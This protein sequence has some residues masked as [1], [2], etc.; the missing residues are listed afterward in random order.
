MASLCAAMFLLPYTGMLLSGGSYYASAASVPAPDADKI[1]TNEAELRAAVDDNAY[2][3]RKCIIMLADDISMTNNALSI[4]SNKDI[5][6]I[7]GHDPESR[8]PYKLIGAEGT[9]TIA[10]KGTLYL[11]GIIVT[12]PA[13]EKGSGVLIES[14]GS[15][16]LL[17]GEVSGNTVTGN[18]GGVYTDGHYFSMEGG[19]ISGNTATGNGGGIYISNRTASGNHDAVVISDDAVISGNSADGNGGGIGVETR[20]EL[21]KLSVHSGTVFSDNSA[22]AAFDRDKSDDDLYNRKIDSDIEW[23]SPLKQGYNNYDIGYIWGDPVLIEEE[24]IE[25]PVPP[26][27]PPEIKEPEDK[28]ANVTPPPVTPPPVTPSPVVQETRL[29]SQQNISEPPEL[30]TQPDEIQPEI[31]EPQ[32]APMSD[33]ITQV[34]LNTESVLTFNPRPTPDEVLA[35]LKDEGVPIL[36][37]GGQET[38]LFSL[39]GLPVWAPIN[40]IL[41]T[42]GAVLAVSSFLRLRK[43]EVDE[44]RSAKRP[45]MTAV[46][47]SAIGVI[48][49]ALTQDTRSLMALFDQWTVLNAVIFAAVIANIRVAFR[50][51]KIY[52]I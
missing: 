39:G 12:H 24:P 50:S 30:I 33:Q 37:I 49:F 13:G 23:T 25:D 29:Y 3:N 20:R 9:E 19:S 38:P 1:V 41:A 10:V 6:L 40:Q 21:E 31:I 43:R 47:L 4:S 26:P 11:D 46:I 18:G 36:T 22:C 17:S 44:Y 7:S 16:Y 35:M 27:L 14:N 2:N 48:V 28:A 45:M 5:T 15:L 32:P 42:I 51:N 34:L 52:D 8:G